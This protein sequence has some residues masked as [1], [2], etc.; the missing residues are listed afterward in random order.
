[1]IK[2]SN[3]SS[4]SNVHERLTRRLAT[5]AWPKISST[6]ISGFW[7]TLL[8]LSLELLYARSVESTFR[9]IFSTL[10]CFYFNLQNL[11]NFRFWPVWLFQTFWHVFDFEW[12]L[13]CFCFSCVSAIW[14]NPAGMGPKLPLRPNSE[15]SRLS[16]PDRQARAR[17]PCAL[18]MA[19]IY[20]Y[21]SW[22]V[23]FPLD[24]LRS[25]EFYKNF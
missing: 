10:H 4:N 7:I 14:G 13:N 2:I 6:K 17:L 9:H 5:L 24:F 25:Q 8:L 12:L 3:C 23:I 15:S 16:L 20:Y 22:L 18:A 19:S 21:F 11:F 1:M